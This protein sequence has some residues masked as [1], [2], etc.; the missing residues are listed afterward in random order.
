MATTKKNSKSTPKKAAT[1]KKKTAAKKP[2]KKVTTKATAKKATTK[3]PVASKKAAKKV[4]TPKK[5]VKKAA[6]PKK[7]SA[8]KSKTVS[9]AVFKREMRKNLLKE[10]DVLLAEINEK[11]RHESEEGKFEIG[12]IYDIASNE[13][14][15][16]LTLM[17]G[18]RERVKIQEIDDALERLSDK[19]YGIC[20]ECE[21][22]IGQ[23]RLRA[24]P[25][26]TSCIECKSNNEQASRFKGKFGDELPVKILEKPYEDEN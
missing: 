14:E 17:L 3:K 25:F 23:E 19:Y 11:V 16:E 9:R 6:A 20:E 13:R 2:L 4:A 15:R 21:E 10:K 26:T 8:V 1:P 24:L 7:K 18:D 22:P 5:V 12:D